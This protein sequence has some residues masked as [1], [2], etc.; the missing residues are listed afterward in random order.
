[1]DKNRKVTYVFSDEHLLFYN[2]QYSVKGWLF[3]DVMFQQK[4]EGNDSLIDFPKLKN[5]EKK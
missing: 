3:G 4:V 5:Q 2:F 1:M